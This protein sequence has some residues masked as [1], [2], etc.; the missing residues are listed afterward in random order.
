[1][2]KDAKGAVIIMIYGYCR[3]STGSQRMDRQVENILRMYPDAKIY[4]EV[5]TG[6]KFYGR[7]EFN[8]LLKTVRKGDVIVFDEVSRMSRDADEGCEVYEKLFLSGVELVFIK[9]PY[10]NT[11]EYSKALERQLNISI[12]TGNV[13]AD[14]LLDSIIDAL[15]KYAVALARQQVRL[16]FEQAQKEVTYLR[17]RTKEGLERRRALGVTLGR[18]E[19]GNNKI[20]RKEPIKNIIKTKSKSF[21][22]YNSDSE[23]IAIINNS[24]VVIEND[25]GESTEIRLSVSRNTYYK[26]KREISYGLIEKEL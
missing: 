1:M 10:I 23:V 26:Y 4:K 8:R 18:P 24:K 25:L 13:A 21:G 20:K 12:S 22:G 9:E 14:E 19:G 2:F 7:D 3:I 11:S 17:R 6:T 16:A 15:S 5:F